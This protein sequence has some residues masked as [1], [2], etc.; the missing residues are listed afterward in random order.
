[1]TLCSLGRSVLVLTLIFGLVTVSIIPL[2]T[3]LRLI[4]KKYNL[5]SSAKIRSTSRQRWNRAQPGDYSSETDLFQP[6]IPALAVTGLSIRALPQ[7]CTHGPI[8]DRAIFQPD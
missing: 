3:P 6:G 4:H 7:G 5:W 8:P 1:M 2:I